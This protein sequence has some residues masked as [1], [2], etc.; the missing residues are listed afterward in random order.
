MLRLKN[1][2][3]RLFFKRI[4]KGT[5]IYSN[6][7]WRHG[8]NIQ[9]GADVRLNNNVFIGGLG[10]VTIEDMVSIG[11]NVVIYSSNH[12]YDKPE[13]IRY[14]GNK[15]KTITISRGA[16]IGSNAVIM[17]NIGEGTVIGAGAVVKNDIPA[18]SVAV[19]VPAK[20]IKNRKPEKNL[21]QTKTPINPKR[22]PL[23]AEAK[24]RLWLIGED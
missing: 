10:G 13:P 12:K 7:H 8:K 17:A 14:Q 16:W 24:W 5:I 11:P 6:L 22:D 1:C 18:W 15:L 9:I 2:W 20:V 19:G 21:I 3:Y 4:G 23:E